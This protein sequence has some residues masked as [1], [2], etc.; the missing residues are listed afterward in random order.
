MK[1][2]MSGCESLSGS[3]TESITQTSEDIRIRFKRTMAS[4][5]RLQ[6]SKTIE[7]L[8]ELPH[9]LI[10]HDSRSDLG[11]LVARCAFHTQ[12]PLMERLAR[13]SVVG[14]FDVDAV[15]FLEEE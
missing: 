8:S 9:L 15:S 11:S 6:T 14:Q 4:A 2:V 10:I 3:I 5:R 1:V 12:N 7:D 13:D